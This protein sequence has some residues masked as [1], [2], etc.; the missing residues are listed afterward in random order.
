MSH[1]RA[2]GP[3]APLRD[4]FPTVFPRRVIGLWAGFLAL[5]LVSCGSPSPDLPPLPSSGD[6][7]WDQYVRAKARYH[8]RL[9]EFGSERWP[10][11]EELFSVSK[12]YQIAALKWRTEQFRYLLE[13]DP[14]RINRGGDLADFVNF[15]WSD[16]DTRRLREKRPETSELFERVR[17]LRE[18]NN[19]HP[20]WPLAR[21]RIRRLP[22]DSTYRDIVSE[23]QQRQ[24][25]IAAEHLP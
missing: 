17:R 10:E 1:R 16:T 22:R 2:G 15:P 7:A 25:D 21:S 4:C 3:G 12:R 6:P 19:Q 20:K 5:V 9:Y 8:I 14:D 11:L 18:Q 24:R 13:H 23:F